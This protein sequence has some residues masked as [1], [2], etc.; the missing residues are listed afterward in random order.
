M[1]L[2]KY[3][4]ELLATFSLAFAVSASLVNDLG[5]I[6][7]I[8]AGLVLGL[9]V[10]TVGGV[11]GAHLNP[12]ITIALFTRK[13]INGTDALLYIASQFLGA[14]LALQLC[15]YLFGAEP[16]ADMAGGTSVLVAEAIGCFFL[17]FGVAFAVHKGTAD[18]SGIVVGGS[19][20]LGI[21]VAAGA[22]NGVVNPAVSIAVGGLSS[23]SLTYLLAP[24]VGAVGAMW[25][26]DYLV[27]TPKKAKKK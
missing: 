12:A 6:T 4:A 5:M 26:Y 1:S 2:Q 10:Y 23:I 27:A 3:V 20:L 25:L 24:I 21:L 17:A 8:I 14:L 9:F 11:S 18:N 7:P 22:S 13:K 15:M 19:L 16:A